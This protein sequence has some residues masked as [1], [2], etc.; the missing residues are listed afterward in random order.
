MAIVRRP[1]VAGSFYPAHAQQLRAAVAAYLAEVSA[2]APAAR[3]KALIAPHAGYIYS[4]P[5]AASVYSPLRP[6]AA[7][8]ERVVLLGPSHRFPLRGLAATAAE[9]FETPIGRVP[10]DREAIERV[11]H[12][13]Q[14]EVLESAHTAEHSLEVQLPFLQHVLGPFSLVPFAVG[15]ASAEQVAEVLRV[16]WEGDETLIVVSSDLSHYYDYETARRLDEATTRAIEALNPDGL[17][18][19]SACGRT[20]LCGLLVEARRRGLAVQTLDLRNSGDTAGPRDQVV[21]Y[22]AYV[23]A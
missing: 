19:E 5:I 22:G 23:L 1:A 13:P 17:G 9:A 6:F 15:D 7:E 12:L 21:G 8:L 3:P 10:V 11:L 14:V 16:L 18:E 4:G 2:E 20:P